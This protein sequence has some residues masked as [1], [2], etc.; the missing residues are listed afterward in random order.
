MLLLQK[1]LIAANCI[2]T[3]K[4]Q[5]DKHRYVILEG[6]TQVSLHKV[7]LIT[8]HPYKD[9]RPV[10]YA[11]NALRYHVFLESRIQG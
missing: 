8:R 4:E 11:Y 5:A 9:I 3:S 6:T 10:S 1:A 7:V 2:G